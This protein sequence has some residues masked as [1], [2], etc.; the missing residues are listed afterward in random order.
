MIVFKEPLKTRKLSADD[1]GISYHESAAFG[2]GDT[3]HHAF[4]EI[5]AVLRNTQNAAQPVLAIQIGT[6]TYTIQY[7]PNDQQHLALI[8]KIITYTRK[9]VGT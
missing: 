4:G 2:M 6:T 9:T 3:F 1:E 5:D 7:K 8:D